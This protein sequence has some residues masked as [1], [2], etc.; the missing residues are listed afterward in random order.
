MNESIRRDG[1]G[2]GSFHRSGRRIAAMMVAVLLSTLWISSCVVRETRVESDSDSANPLTQGN[3]QLTLRSGV[4]TKHEV[5]E[6][7]GA[8]N[9]TTRDGEGREVWTYQRYGH[10][11]ESS[12]SSSYATILLFGTQSDR[13]SLQE[14]NRSMT[15]IITFNGQD[16]VETFNSRSSS[17]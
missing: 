17:F 2:M 11:I 9:V 3:V 5:L 8:P 13:D 14:T 16:I 1:R 15:L 12:R 10:V 4:T 6:T 7:F